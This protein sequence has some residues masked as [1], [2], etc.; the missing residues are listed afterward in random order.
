[1]KKFNLLFV[2]ILGILFFTFGCSCSTEQTVSKEE[3]LDVL[4]SIEM[5]ENVKITTTTE[6]V[7][8]NQKA[9]T[10]QTDYYYGDKYYHVSEGEDISTKTWY[11]YVEDALYAFYYTKNAEDVEVKNSSR[12]EATQLESIKN[13]PTSVVNSLLTKEGTLVEGYELN[14]TRMGNRYTIQASVNGEEESDVYTITI[15]NN[16]IT[17]LKKTNGVEQNSIKVTYVYE[18]D[19]DDFELP[20]LNEYPLNVNN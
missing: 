5:D 13:Q 9:T 20:S 16:K 14:A 12:I 17:K 4:K 6:T 10:I 1:M 8:N 18:Y 11:G 15:I 19:I 7:V 3:A 2:L